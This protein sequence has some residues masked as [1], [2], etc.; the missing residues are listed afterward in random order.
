MATKQ[1]ASKISPKASAE[2][3]A[4]PAPPA[5]PRAPRVTSAKHSKTVASEPVVE[6]PVAK[7]P[8][9]AVIAV[10]NPQE[11]IA[12]IAY[13]YWEARGYMGGDQVQDWLR[14]EAEFKTRSL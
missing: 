8:V 9:V 1:T 6:T 5:K 11:A 10:E 14:A 13:G 7:T 4:V 12:K 3:A 2:K